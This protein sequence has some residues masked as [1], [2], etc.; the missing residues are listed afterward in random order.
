MLKDGRRIKLIFRMTLGKPPLNPENEVSLVCFILQGKY[1][2]EIK[3]FVEQAILGEGITFGEAALGVNTG[4]T[5]AN[6]HAKMPV[7][8]VRTFRNARI[9]AITDLH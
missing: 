1:V 8:K 2:H 4:V 5:N 3:L 7:N 9:T 6:L